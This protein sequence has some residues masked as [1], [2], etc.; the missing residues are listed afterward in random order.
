[1]LPSEKKLKEIGESLHRTRVKQNITLETIVA[2]T[3]I[4]KRIIIAIEQG[5]LQE[6]PEPFYTKALLGKYAKAVGYTGI[7]DYEEPPE[8][9]KETLSNTKVNSSKVNSPKKPTFQLRSRHLYLIYLILVIVAVRAIAS[10][11]ENP[12]VVDNQ[13]PEEEIT[14]DS[15][16]PITESTPTT[17]SSASPSEFVSQSSSNNSESV[18]V[19][20]TLKDR[21]WLKVIVDGKVEF[22]G[23]LP[24]GTQRSWT[25]EEQIDIIAGNA[26]GVV[27]TYNHGQ[28]KLLGKPGQV[29]E[30]TYTVN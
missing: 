7:L 23:T 29:E 19:D 5:N 27:I 22:E 24:Q 12:L 8:E 4:S 10:F 25:G 11:V 26:G 9:P 2:Q 16:P 6:L 14:L 21:C 20:I 30:V 13:I 28:E 3:L 15:D 18:V 17:I 1:M